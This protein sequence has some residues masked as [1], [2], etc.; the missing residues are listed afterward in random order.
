MF[1]EGADVSGTCSNEI[2]SSLMTEDG[3]GDIMTNL[4]RAPMGGWERHTKGIGSRLLA[5]M[6]YEPGKGLGKA[7]DGIVDPVQAT[8]IP[9]GRLSQRLFD[10]LKF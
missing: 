6:G 2:E 7:S 8:R 10:F 3:H 5:K 1:V 9:K 4:P